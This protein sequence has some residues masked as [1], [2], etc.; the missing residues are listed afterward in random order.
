MN[1]KIAQQ[2]LNRLCICAGKSNTSLEACLVSFSRTAA[3]KILECN[4]MM[5]VMLNMWAKIFYDILKYCS[6][7]FRQIGSDDFITNCL[8]LCM[9]FQALFSGKNNV[10]SKLSLLN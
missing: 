9:K 8:L 2:T 3:P 4:R 5:T 10:M 6:Y 1:K 7:F